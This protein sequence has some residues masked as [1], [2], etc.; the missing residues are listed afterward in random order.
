[1]LAASKRS[2]LYC[3]IS[4]IVFISCSKSSGQ[5]G[6]SQAKGTYTGVMTTSTAHYDN[7]VVRVEHSSKEKIKVS[8]QSTPKIFETFE[9][10]VTLVN[11]TINTYGSIEV[12]CQPAVNYLG[13]DSWNGG[14]ILSYRGY[15]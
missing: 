12:F 3:L 10:K 6:A 13:L 5:E 14:N 7:Y 9:A 2:L 1:M 15:N 8:C 4:A 11:G